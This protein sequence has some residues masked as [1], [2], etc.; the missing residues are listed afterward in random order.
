[1]TTIPLFTS[2]LNRLPYRGVGKTAKTAQSRHRLSRLLMGPEKEYS[3][4]GLPFER[5]NYSKSAAAKLPLL[6]HLTRNILK[7]TRSAIPGNICKFP[8]INETLD[9]PCPNLEYPG[10]LTS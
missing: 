7:L 2:S 5:G 10:G 8:F 3:A 6:T 1:M 4:P 9:F